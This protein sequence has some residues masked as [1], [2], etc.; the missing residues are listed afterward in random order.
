MKGFLNEILRGLRACPKYLPAKYFYDETGDRLFQQIMSSPEY[1]LTRCEYE[2]FSLK[3]PAIADL[4]QSHLP[5]FDLVEL[6]AGDCLKSRFLLKELV[7]RNLS[8]TF[9]PVDISANVIEQLTQTLPE[10]IPGLKLHGLNGEYLAMLEKARQ[11]SD[12]PKVV[13]FL[14]A[15]IGNLEKDQTGIFLAQ[16]RATLKKGD[17]LCIGFDLKKD[18]DII[19]SAYNDKAGLTRA[20]NLNLL[21]RINREFEADFD[22]TAFKHFPVYDPVSGACRSFLISLKQQRV[23]MK[24]AGESFCFEPYEPVFMEISQKYSRDEILALALTSGFRPL[25][26]FCDSKHWF[27]DAIWEV[28]DK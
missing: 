6:G 1:Y 26:T 24:T 10:A 16:I 20:F 23:N 15:N 3:T 22:L 8:F 25:T 17:L 18:P 21:K 5:L 12:R 7:H 27:G 28:D 9:Y 13:L 14:G 2:I 19:L 11:L 4:L